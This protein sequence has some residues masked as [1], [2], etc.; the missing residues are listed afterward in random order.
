MENEVFSTDSIA[1]VIGRTQLLYLDLSNFSDAFG[2][3]AIEIDSNG[4]YSSFTLVD[5][6]EPDAPIYPSGM[7]PEDNGPYVY[8]IDT[9]SIRVGGHD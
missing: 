3:F 7:I 9:L 6:F 4:R 8:R 5:D 2:K 1:P